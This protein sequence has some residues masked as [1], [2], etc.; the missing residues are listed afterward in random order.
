[1]TKNF[2]QKIKE[3]SKKAET[4]AV[5]VLFLFGI[6]LQIFNPN[7]ARADELSDLNNKLNELND[8]INLINSQ[9]SQKRLEKKTL[10]DEVAIFDDQI[11]AITLQISASNTSINKTQT[12]IDNILVEIKKAEEELINQKDLLGENL[13]IFYEEGQISSIE[14]IASSDNFSEYL[15]RSEYLRSLQDKIVETVDKINIL[16]KELEEKQKGLETKKAELLTVKNQQEGQKQS[17]DSQKAAKDSLLVYTKGEEASFQN[18][19]KELQASYQAIQNQVTAFIN[20]GNFVSQ[21]AVKKGS[22]IGYEGNSGYSSGAHLHF[23][24]RTTNG[25]RLNPFGFL[26]S[27]MIWPMENYILTQGF[28]ENPGLYGTGGHPGVDMAGPYGEP[29]KAVADGDI[30]FSG[31]SS[32]NTYPGGPLSY[33]RYIIINHNNG[34]FTLYAHLK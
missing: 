28:G 32:A 5:L 14:V 26:G 1:M 30:I 9:L 16:R 11:Y 3:K 22:I 18:N 25:Q 6:I 21:G 15:D 20:Q 7:M 31:G 13:R 34:Y 27:S 4:T 33:G 12:E 17:L 2:F 23:E 24:V 10:Q 29:V 8:Q 19:L